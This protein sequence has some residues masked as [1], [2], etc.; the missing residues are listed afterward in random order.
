LL[1]RARQR[2][3]QELAPFLV[4]AEVVSAQERQ[5]DEVELLPFAL[6]TGEQEEAT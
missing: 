4:F 3:V 5:H 1:S 6:M 2:D